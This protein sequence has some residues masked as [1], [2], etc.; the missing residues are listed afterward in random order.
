MTDTED[1]IYIY[2]LFKKKCKE[3]IPNDNFIDTLKS[4]KYEY[5][6]E[7][8]AL[9]KKL[10]EK[11]IIDKKWFRLDDDQFNCL[12]TQRLKK[13]HLFTS[14]YKKDKLIVMGSKCLWNLYHAVLKIEKIELKNFK[15]A[16]FNQCRGC[17]EYKIN[18][19]EHKL[20]VNDYYCKN[21]NVK[22]HVKFECGHFDVFDENNYKECYLCR[23]ARERK[24]QEEKEKMIQEEKEKKWKKRLRKYKKTGEYK[25]CVECRKKKDNIEKKRCEKCIKKIKIEKENK[26][27]LLELELF[28]KYNVYKKCIDCR[29]PKKHDKWKKCY[30]CN[31]NNMDK[32]KCGKNKNKENEECWNCKTKEWRMCVECGLNKV[33]PL[34]LICWNCNK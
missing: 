3:Y 6:T 26:E 9:L 5:M 14:K 7:D 20:K 27:W 32:C 33:N 13:N 19:N 30:D 1:L 10:E 16:M 34:Y 29:K 28:E 8:F 4:F 2:N 18:K 12:C 24:Q 15:E 21:C 11:G 17:K 31:M 22:G 25:R 23:I